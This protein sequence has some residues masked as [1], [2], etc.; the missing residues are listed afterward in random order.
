MRGAGLVEIMVSMVLGLLLLAGVFQVYQSSRQSQTLQDAVTRRQ[1]ALRYATLMMTRDLRMSGY[2]GCLRDTGRVVNTLNNPAAYLYNFAF[3]VQGS[4]SNGAGWS[5]AVDASVVPVEPGTDVLTLRTVRDNVTIVRQAM[6]QSSADLKVEA[7]LNPAPFATQGD[8][9][10][11]SDCGGAAIF[12]I[13]NYTQT[14]GNIV[15]NAGVAAPAPGNA[16]K[17]LGRRYP[18]GA[19]I[20]LISTV[21]YF[22]RQGSA[23]RGPSLWRRIGTST[24]EELVE[25]VENL[26]VQYGEDTDGDNVPDDY[27]NADLVADWRRVTAVRAA[28]LATASGQ[29]LSQPDPRRFEMLDEWVGPFNDRRLRRVITVTVGLRNRL[30]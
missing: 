30:S 15:H 29:P 20:S 4:E 24:P 18:V 13:T 25:G 22:V 28:L 16:T 1:E 6:P 5:P 7:N 21:S 12:Q 10:L 8:I 9:V 23:G 17:N 2:R 26:Q 3:H 27:R 11:V 14:N 19:E